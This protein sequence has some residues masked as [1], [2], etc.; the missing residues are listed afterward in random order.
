MPRYERDHDSLEATLKETHET[1]GRLQAL[2]DD[3]TSKIAELKTDTGP[4]H[5][6]GVP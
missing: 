3:L 4:G 1:V 2:I 5:Q 6:K